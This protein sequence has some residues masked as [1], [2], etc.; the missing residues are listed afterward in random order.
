MHEF[1]VSRTIEAPIDEVW[2]VLADFGNIS[3]WNPG[4][5][6]SYLTG[7]QSGDVGAT[8]HCDLEPLGA[9]K[10]RIKGWVPDSELVIEIYE[11]KALPMKRGQAIF[12]VTEAGSAT[13]VTVAYSY[14]PTLVGRV[15]G[16]MG[17]RAFVKGFERLLGGLDEYVTDGAQTR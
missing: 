1:T 4:V 8:R 13:E 15:M 9:V 2:E 11:A 7:D 16:D 17:K 10:E 12:R 3:K 6:K 14:T 5:T